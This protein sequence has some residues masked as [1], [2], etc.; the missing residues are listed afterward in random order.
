MEYGK[1]ILPNESDFL[2][3][4]DLMRVIK[5]VYL[6]EPLTSDYF[7]KFSLRRSEYLKRLLEH[8]MG[9]FYQ[10]QISS[11]KIYNGS[12]FLQ[13]VGTFDTWVNKIIREGIAEY[14]DWHLNGPHN[15]QSKL[16][17]NTMN[18]ENL[19]T[20]IFYRDDIDVY[21]EGYIFVRPILE[22][23]VEYGVIYLTRYPPKAHDL[24]YPDKY[25]ERF[26]SFLNKK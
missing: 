7:T 16:D 18:P 3:D 6:F 26:R 21:D 5:F 14:F 1:L 4:N 25:Y 17:R 11:Y 12:E 9:H 19:A 23:S 15:I 24:F 20:Y 10:D 13:P 2:V 22:D 8:E